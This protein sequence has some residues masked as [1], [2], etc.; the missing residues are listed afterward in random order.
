[1]RGS[2]DTRL[3]AVIMLLGVALA[4]PAAAGERPLPFVAEYKAS[5]AGFSGDIRMELAPAGTDDEFIYRVT[6]RARGLA[7]LI[8]PGTATEEARF[9]V[10]DDRLIPLRYSIDDGTKKGED[11][12]SID[13]DWSSGTAHSVYEQSAEK[14]ELEPDVHDRLTTD[15][16][17]MRSLRDGEPLEHFR[18]AEK[19]AIRDYEFVYRG[20]ETIEVPAGQFA[21]RKYLRQ[22]IGS[23]RATLIWF[24][25]ALDYLP[26]RIEQLKRGKTS[27]TTVATDISIDGV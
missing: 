23:S 27:I 18:I 1:M 11:D 10:A 3:K 6:T 26:V 15:L 24:A 17:V 9:R 7:R 2:L 13:F 16:K 21:T 5:Y 14:L 20:E 25:P 4:G 12:T 22:R 19:N 8:R